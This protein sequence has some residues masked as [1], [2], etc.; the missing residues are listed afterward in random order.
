MNMI[1]QAIASLLYTCMHPLLTRLI[2]YIQSY[3][4]TNRVIDI[5]VSLL[6]QH[7]V[8]LGGSATRQHCIQPDCLVWLKLVQ[9]NAKQRTNVC[10]ETDVVYTF[11]YCGY[12]A[13]I[14]HAK[15]PSI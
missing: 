14:S 15:T 11:C 13:G 1:M 2:T 6:T 8:W 12:F 4:Q 7:L 5:T 9:Q 10:S 3:N